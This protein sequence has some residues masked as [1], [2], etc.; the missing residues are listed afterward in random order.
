MRTPIAF[1]YGNCV[2]ARGLRDVWAGF[3]LE[4]SSYEWLG[5]V[6]KHGRLAAIVGAIEAVG[7]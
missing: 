3:A 7:A 6:E 5:D 2:F 4:L 1:I